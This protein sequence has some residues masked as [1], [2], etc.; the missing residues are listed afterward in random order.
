MQAT[1]LIHLRHKYATNTSV[2][3]LHPIPS[4]T[5]LQL[6]HTLNQSKFNMLQC[7]HTAMYQKDTP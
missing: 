2:P 5:L 3:V 1:L 7:K 6:M 4:A